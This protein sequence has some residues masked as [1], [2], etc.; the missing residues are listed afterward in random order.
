MASKVSRPA[1]ASSGRTLARQEAYIQSF[2]GRFSAKALVTTSTIGEC[3]NLS[4]T[5]SAGANS[6]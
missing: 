5:R 3:A 6:I 2:D 4:L 1:P